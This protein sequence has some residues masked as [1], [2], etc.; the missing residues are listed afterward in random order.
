MIALTLT[1]ASEAYFLICYK[2][3]VLREREKDV[4]LSLSPPSLSSKSSPFI[5]N[6]GTCLIRGR[7]L[8][9]V[10]QRKLLGKNRKFSFYVFASLTSL[11]SLLYLCL[12]VPKVEFLSFLTIL[13]SA[14]TSIHSQYFFFPPPFPP[15]EG[16]QPNFFLLLCSL[17]VL[18]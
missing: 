5:K 10:T 3:Y 15:C 12:K 18:A 4:P 6:C 2:T 14:L 16:Y 9:R 8:K 1:L 13:E 17:V 11:F 7:K